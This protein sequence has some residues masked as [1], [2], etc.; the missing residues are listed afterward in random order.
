MYKRIVNN[1]VGKQPNINTN[2]EVLHQLMKQPLKESKLDTPKFQNFV[3]NNYHQADLL[4]LPNDKNYKYLLV[5]VDIS[6]RLIDAEQ[7]KDKNSSNIVKAFKKIYN[8]RDILKIPQTI[9]FDSGAEFR[10]ETEK[11]FESI[12]VNVKYADTNRH[13]QQAMVESAN[14]KIGKIIF[15]IQNH[16]ELQTNKQSKVWVKHLREIINELNNHSI[17][18]KKITPI[19]ELPVITETNKHLLNIGDK[20]RVKL[21]YPID[22]HNNKRLY[23]KF[24]SGDIKW[25]INIY[26]IRELLIRPGFPPMYLTTKSKTTQ[27]TTQQLQVIK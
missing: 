12:N 7:L 1:I 18:T 21:D 22:I 27:Y 25:T 6:S 14:Q 10:G 5:V 2:T 26:K 8:N 11:Y 13:R 17:K 24:R 4:F 9:S 23:G 16:Q 15:M 19:P 3:K 20:V